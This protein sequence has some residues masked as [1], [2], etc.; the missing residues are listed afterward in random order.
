MRRMSVATLRMADPTND[1]AARIRL[2]GDTASIGGSAAS[3]S[4]VVGA[5]LDIARLVVVAHRLD[6]EPGAL[7]FQ[8]RPASARPGQ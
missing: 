8:D 4:A 7:C 1:V 5:T 6:A 2:G 3:S